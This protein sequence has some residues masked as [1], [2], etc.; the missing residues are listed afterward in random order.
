MVAQLNIENGTVST[1]W[2][3]FSYP[4]LC[5][6]IAG[7]PTKLSS[8]MHNTAFLAARVPF[9]FSAFAV[10]D[11]RK[12]LTAMR[13]LGM[14]GFCVTIPHKETVI[15]LLDLL[16]VEAKKIGAV[17]TVINTGNALVGENT[18][19]LGIVD[20]LAEQHVPVR[21]KSVLIF[22]AGGA[23]CAALYA[24][25]QQG[26]TDLCLVNRTEDRA[27]A[28]ADRFGAKTLS[29]AEMR[30][31]IYA[32]DIDLFINS[33]PIGS[34][35]HP[36]TGSAFGVA[37]DRTTPPLGRA[38]FDMVTRDTPLLEHARSQGSVVIP[39]LRMLL[40]QAVRQFELFT[41]QEAPVAAMEEALRQQIAGSSKQK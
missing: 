9:V 30:D 28:L 1:D 32:M 29:V 25:Q 12:P 20:A 36:D 37:L 10:S 11:P 23:A 6:I 40:K 38:V 33:T 2:A 18:D 34:H 27:K 26:C 22:G 5:G 19:W 35:L 3:R 8:A 13:D 16:T 21:G 41:E 31:R 39:G 4:R 14:R 7:S 17:N 24:L 15:P